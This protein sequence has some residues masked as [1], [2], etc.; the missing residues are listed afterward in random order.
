M[1]RM[2]KFHLERSSVRHVDLKTTGC[3]AMV[4]CEAD[5]DGWNTKRSGRIYWEAATAT[6]SWLLM[7]RREDQMSISINNLGSNGS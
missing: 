2:E 5:G 6:G 7:K 1:S 4:S 3:L